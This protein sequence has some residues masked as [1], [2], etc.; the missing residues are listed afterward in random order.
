MKGRRVSGIQVSAGRDGPN[1]VPGGKG[2]KGKGK[3][4]VSSQSTIQTATADSE[5]DDDYSNSSDEI[6]EFDDFSDDEF[7]E[8]MM[9]VKM[10]ENDPIVISDDEDDVAMEGVLPQGGNVGEAADKDRQYGHRMTT[11]VSDT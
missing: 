11:Q 10:E 5:D 6:Q 2:S 3:L 1:V 8:E 9:L 7:G 4:V